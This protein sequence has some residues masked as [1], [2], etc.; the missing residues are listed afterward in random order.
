M[1]KLLEKS[2]Y[3]AIVGVLSLLVAAVAALAWG[4]FQTVHAVVL[5]VE[6]LGADVGITV[7]LVE[8]VD[9]FLVATTLLIFAASLYELF[10]ADI[11]LP[12]W[13]LAHNLHDLK[14]KLG[15]MIVLVMAVKFVEKLV[16]VKNYDDLLKFGAAISLVSAVL[17]AFGH[18][19]HND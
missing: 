18:F 10:I 16:E 9:S 5:I 17:I 13:M 11:N 4:V 6:S 3:L 19:G 14:A 8:I 1:S 12:D 7:A 15:S 2:R